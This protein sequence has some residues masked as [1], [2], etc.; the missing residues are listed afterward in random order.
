[1]S[2]TE[3]ATPPPKAVVEPET[4]ELKEPSP[5]PAPITDEVPEVV[6][7]PL[8]DAEPPA[9]TTPPIEPE[10]GEPTRIER[11]RGMTQGEKIAAYSE[12]AR[13]EIQAAK[14]RG[15]YTDPDKA[16]DADTAISRNGLDSSQ[17][18]K[19]LLDSLREIKDS[20]V[21]AS[22]Y[23]KLA[24]ETTVVLGN[25]RIVLSDLEEKLKTASDEEKEGIREILDNG[26]Y[27]F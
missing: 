1:M 22:A 3:G 2:E 13:I 4:P 7:I 18:I 20:D 27:E 10:G 9:E 14:A 17:N 21:A 15:I 5:E 8:P 11:F 16:K 25:E 12:V 23:Q 26:R 24:Q 6:D 19:T